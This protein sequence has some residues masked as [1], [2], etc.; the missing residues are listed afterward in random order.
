[1]DILFSMAQNFTAMKAEK[2]LKRAIKSGDEE[3]I[4]NAF[5]RLYDENVRLVYR[6]LIDSFG[7]DDET[8]DDVQ[9][10]FLALLQNPRRLLAI[11]QIAEYWVISAK[12]ICGHRREKQ[13]RMSEVFEEDAISKD[14]PIPE[15]VQGKELFAKIER[16][17]GHPDSD[18]VVFHAAYGYSERE[19]AELIGM[20]EDAISYR[21][22]KGIKELRKRLKDEEE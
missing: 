22:R 19:I 5:K 9:E 15:M 8:D 12:Y 10:S 13:K 3:R 11:D 17:L 6:V 18:I 1:M 4:M 16:W 2:E 7:K 14:H 20:G 21:Y